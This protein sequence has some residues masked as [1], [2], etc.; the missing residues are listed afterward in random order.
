[1]KAAAVREAAG[2]GCRVVAF[3]NSRS[4]AGMGKKVLEAL[5]E[6]LGNDAVFDLGENPHPERVL[7][8]PALV[9]ASSKANGG[10]RI[11]VCGGDGT[12]TWVMS[13]VD[14]VVEDLE[15]DPSQHAFYVAMMPLGT[16]NDLSRTFGWGGA[17]RDACLRPAWVESVKNA[18]PE[19]L[20]RWLV[21]VMPSAALQNVKLENVPEIFS[22]HEYQAN[23]GAQTLQRRGLH[24][25]R[26]SAE[27]SRLLLTGHDD[28][29]ANDARAVSKLGLNVVVEDATAEDVAE[30]PAA[31]SDA[32][33]SGVAAPADEPAVSPRARPLILPSESVL[34]LGRK[35][36][37]YDGTFSN[38]F[39]VGVDA[40]A[41]TAFHTARR[42]NPPRF[43]SRAKNQA[44]YAWLGVLATGGICGCGGP[45]KRLHEFAELECRI[46][47]DE[48]DKLRD[49]EQVALPKS[50]RGL[51]VLNLRSYAGGRNLWGPNSCARDGCGKSAPAPQPCDGVLEIVTTDG[52]FDLASS[53]CTSQGLGGRARRLVRCSEFRL[54]VREACCMQIDGEPWKQPPATVHL[55]CIGQSDVLAHR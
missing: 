31:A 27:S 52:I 6:H 55:S 29:R 24:Y 43:N 50:A 4:G 26:A 20:D 45:P 15:L 40:A 5:R 17:F 11:I 10:L 51:I 13:A 21:A 8:A 12:M 49:W 2:T 7:A 48:D 3:S 44:L 32:A 42:S 19:R 28:A 14:A 39:S 38:Y 23:G 25:S 22:V 53:L 36:T 18:E 37:S 47:D 30:A 33:A 9:A 41:A 46:V 16:G 35:Y 54:K 34:A 1:M